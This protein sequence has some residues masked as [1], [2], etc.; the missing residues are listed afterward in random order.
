MIFR[1]LP[2]LF[3]S[4]FAFASTSG[5]LLTYGRDVSKEHRT[6]LNNDI[7]LLNVWPLSTSIEADFYQVTDVTGPVSSGVDLLKWLSERISIVTGETFD[8]NKSI[9]T[10]SAKYDF[11][12]PGIL[13]DLSARMTRSASAQTKMSVVM[14]NMGPV[15]YYLGKSQGKL[16]G[17]DLAGIGKIPVST[18]RV[19]LLQ[20]GPGLFPALKEGKLTDLDVSLS[21]L[22][23]LFHEARHSD[24]RGAAMGM[25]HI[26]CPVGHAYAG[27][28]AC[29]FSLNGAYS[30]EGQI[31]KL[32]TEN[33]SKCTIAQK[34]KL[35]L[36][37]LD[38]FSRVVKEKR[39]IS[40]ETENAQREAC[41]KLVDY[42]VKVPM[43][44]ELKARDLNPPVIPRAQF[45]DSRPEGVREKRKGFF[46]RL[47]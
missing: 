24:G 28:P 22:F 21:R 4:S 26:Y 34:E 37:Y 46:E 38:S 18:P 12:L 9:Y 40:Q 30:V 35:R 19:G 27:Y 13:P 1:F 15:V 10:E 31:A 44:D 3:L 8:L 29:D 2:F 7:A 41:A 20:I 5:P 23:T 25:M 39:T 33:C 43:C 16:F 11:Q 6:L 36:G 45:L 32:M 42:P 14:A 17:V 47:F